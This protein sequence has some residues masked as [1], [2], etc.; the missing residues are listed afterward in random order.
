M[1]FAV[2]LNKDELPLFSPQCSLKSCLRFPLFPFHA[3]ASVS[4]G[5]HRDEAQPQ[6]RG[7]LLPKP[8][9]RPW[10]PAVEHQPSLTPLSSPLSAVRCEHR[11]VEKQQGL[12]SDRK[13]TALFSRKKK[14]LDVGLI[15]SPAGCAA[16]HKP[17]VPPPIPACRGQHDVHLSSWPGRKG[18][19]HIQRHP[20][21][22]GVS[23]VAREPP[24]S[25]PVKTAGGS[26]LFGLVT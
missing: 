25:S 1:F 18:W 22:G 26:E 11:Y 9:P 15:L 7:I 5:E 24:N 6:G 13:P 2:K 10:P 12:G 23:V 14:M 16:V 20:G 8:G 19:M 3:G 21:R 17:T 4:S